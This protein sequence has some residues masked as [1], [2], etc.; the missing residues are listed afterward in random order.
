[1]PSRR[2]RAPQWVWRVEAPGGAGPMSQPHRRVPLPSSHARA[3]QVARWNA[4]YQVWP[5][6]DFDPPLGRAS[7]SWRY[8]YGFATPEHAT[9]WFG[10]DAL[11][12]LATLGFA[13]RRVPASE[14]RQSISGRQLAFVPHRSYRK[15]ARDPVAADW[16]NECEDA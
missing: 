11:A 7:G 9:A 2:Y 12:E 16:C 4:A 1:M 15:S 3:K 14:V 13:L 6:E 5:S 10:A 8:L